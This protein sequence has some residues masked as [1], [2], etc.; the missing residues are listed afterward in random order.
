MR[1]RISNY[2]ET[3]VIVVISNTLAV[4]SGYFGWNV[5]ISVVGIAFSIAGFLYYRSRV[6]AFMFSILVLLPFFIIYDISVFY[7]GLVHV[8]PIAIIPLP[9]LLFGMLVRI[10][11]SKNRLIAY[12]LVI[13]FLI[14]MFVFWKVLMPNYLSYAFSINERKIEAERVDFPKVNFTDING[15]DVDVKQFEGN[16]VVLD[17]WST[18][19]GVCFRCFPDFHE[20]ISKY[21]DNGNVMFYAIAIV[22]PHQRIEEAR[23]KAASL[24]Y[25]FSYLFI[26]NDSINQAFNSKF[27]QTVPTII[28][29]DKDGKI[30][31]IDRGSIVYDAYV[32][33]N[34]GYKLDEILAK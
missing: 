11:Y 34:V 15:N 21:K 16:V 8:Y 25:D 17:F 10:I 7:N 19:C 12:S 3:T 31:Y 33:R 2:L 6:S 29:I 24:P 1:L 23:T 27:V 20:L 5:Q 14:L 28:I 32:F 9:A 18:T 26:D 30:V 13:V 4:L 22:N